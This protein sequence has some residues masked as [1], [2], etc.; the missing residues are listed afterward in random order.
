MYRA[1]ADSI[2]AEGWFGSLEVGGGDESPGVGGD[3]VRTTERMLGSWD[4]GGGVMDEVV[5]GA[6]DVNFSIF[7]TGDAEHEAERTSG[8]AGLDGCVEGITT[9][10]WEACDIGT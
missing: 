8:V 10:S 1:A 9:D 5:G 7:A 3:G 6:G 2:R 4:D